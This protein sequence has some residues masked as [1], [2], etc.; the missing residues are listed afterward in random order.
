MSIEKNNKVTIVT[1]DNLGECYSEFY[2][3]YLVLCQD[4]V[5]IKMRSSAS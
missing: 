4:L 2:E 5:Q 3:Y 1:D